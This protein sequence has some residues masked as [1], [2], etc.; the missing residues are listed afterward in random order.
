MMK[1]GTPLAVD[2]PGKA[3]TNPGFDGVGEPSGRRSGSVREPS[4]RSS[5]A[6]SQSSSTRRAPGPPPLSGPGARQSSGFG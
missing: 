1:F 6:S 3:S 4:G 5:G 2:G